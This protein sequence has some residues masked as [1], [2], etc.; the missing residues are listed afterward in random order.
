MDYYQILEIERSSSQEV[1]AH[2]FKRLSLKYSPNKN[3]SLQG[4][5]QVRFNAICE[6]YEVLSNLEHKAVFDKYG[7]YGLKNGVKNDKGETV[8]GY[9][10]L[11]NSD[12]IFE[13]FFSRKVPF[14]PDNFEDNASDLYGSILGDGHGGK[15]QKRPAAPKDLEIKVCC[16]LKEFYNGSMKTAK[17]SRDKIY[18]DGRSIKK[19]DEE[20]SIEV[21]PG[22]DVKTVLTFPGKGNEQYTHSQSKL[23]VKFTM[24]E[25]ISQKFVRRG[26]N[27]IYTHS[28]SLEDALR[29]A[30]IA[31][32]TLDGRPMSINLDQPITPQTIHRVEGEGMPKLENKDLFS[33]LETLKT[34]P[35]GDLF[36]KFDIHFPNNLT[37]E[38]RQAIVEVLRKN[39]EETDE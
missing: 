22:F 7:E 20:L 25:S 31:F 9:I 2:A 13:A 16:S 19:V 8:G 18:P 5:S 39:A 33:H 26:D 28:L 17:Y 12:E 1:V 29:S 4:T 37:I 27:L 30:T 21:K 35:K 24:D 14:K 34:M 15:S 11:G 36:I 23:I 6:S 38:K 32:S 3:P 10:F